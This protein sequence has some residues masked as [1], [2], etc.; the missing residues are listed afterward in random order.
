M[1]KIMEDVA[2]ERSK[3]VA[4]NMLADGKLSV[5]DIAKYSGLTVAEVKA[6]AKKKSA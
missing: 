6:L 4:L 2:N 1:C 5:K 3:Q